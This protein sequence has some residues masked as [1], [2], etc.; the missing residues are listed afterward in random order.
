MFVRYKRFLYR[1][2]S[3]SDIAQQIVSFLWDWIYR[4]GISREQVESL[5][6][7]LFTI[8][9]K[10]ARIPK[11]LLNAV[12]GLIDKIGRTETLNVIKRAIS[13][14]AKNRWSKEA[15]TLPEDII[16]PILQ[17]L[18]KAKIELGEFILLLDAAVSNDPT[19]ILE[20][21]NLKIPADLASK[22]IGL[23]S[24]QSLDFVA[25]M[26]A[27]DDALDKPPPG[28]R[29]RVDETGKRVLAR[30][31]RKN[32]REPA[33]V[34]GK[35][36]A[37]SMF[38]GVW[39]QAEKNESYYTQAIENWLKN[40]NGG[41]FYVNYDD[42]YVQYHGFAILDEKEEFA[43]YEIC[44]L[45]ANFKKLGGYSDIRLSVISMIGIAEHRA[46]HLSDHKH[47]GCIRSAKYNWKYNINDVLNGRV[48]EYKNSG[49]YNKLISAIRAAV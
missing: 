8:G 20:T 2:A 6:S 38:V 23:L 42:D 44:S 30:V 16:I 28:Y 48:V 1:E 22:V 43:T 40:H 36:F 21:E 13:N 33:I 3:T 25:F 47:F 31:G 26:S 29:W 10:I 19:P 15:D 7:R 34:R 18:S 17:F 27:V 4:S 49:D 45:A 5:L 24:E 9:Q 46:V 37:T 12:K 39:W 32:T 14:F 41:V 11:S 35:R